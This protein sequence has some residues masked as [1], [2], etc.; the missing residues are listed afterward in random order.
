MS[1]RL[2]FAGRWSLPLV[3]VFSSSEFLSAVRAQ[4]AAG[5]EK[6]MFDTATASIIVMVVAFI[7]A[8]IIALCILYIAQ[9]MEVAEIVQEIKAA[10]EK[11]EEEPPPA[12]EEEEGEGEGEGE[13]EKAEEEPPDE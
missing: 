13:G 5:G 1:R 9:S 3:F 11:K 8:I 12:A 10:E 4:K 7:V 2:H 6:K